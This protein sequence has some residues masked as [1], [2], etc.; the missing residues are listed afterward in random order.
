MFDYILVYFLA[1]LKRM[2]TFQPK[3]TW[4]SLCSCHGM[5]NRNISEFTE[6]FRKLWQEHEALQFMGCF[7]VCSK[8][9][10][11]VFTLSC[12]FANV[13]CGW[14]WGCTAATVHGQLFSLRWFVCPGNPSIKMFIYYILEYYL[15]P[16]LGA[17][18]GISW[19]SSW[20]GHYIWFP[21]LLDLHFHLFLIQGTVLQ[22]ISWNSSI[23]P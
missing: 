13:S 6:T 5:F 4:F 17:I 14:W 9:Q 8:T 15:I 21:E 11:Q 7:T 12:C 23:L 3:T 18:S 19:I 2:L 10:N 20:G 16:V 1:M 22:C